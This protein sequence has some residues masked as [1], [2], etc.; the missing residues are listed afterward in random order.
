M[1]R[2]TALATVRRHETSPRK[3]GVQ[4]AAI[5]GSVA[6]NEARP[7]SDVDIMIEIDPTL[8]MGVFAYVGLKRKVAELFPLRVDVVSRSALKPFIRTSALADA[9]YAF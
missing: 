7:Y 3:L 1:D 6:R 2:E 9:V 8:R 5:F 4:H